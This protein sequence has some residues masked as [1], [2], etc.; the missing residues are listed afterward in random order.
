MDLTFSAW[1]K[2]ISGNSSEKIV[3][4][5]LKE[6]EGDYIVFFSVTKEESRED[7]GT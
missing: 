1:I 3:L 4:C 5:A 7:R 6:M 2:S